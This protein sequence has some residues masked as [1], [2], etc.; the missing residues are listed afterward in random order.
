MFSWHIPRRIYANYG[1]SV[2][3]NKLCL[4]CSYSYTLL[5]DIF[6]QDHSSKLLLI[7]S[8]HVAGNWQSFY[9]DFNLRQVL[10]VNWFCT[11]CISWKKKKQRNF[12][13]CRN[14]KIAARIKCNATRI[15]GNFFTSV[16]NSK[17]ERIS[18]TCHCKSASSWLCKLWKLLFLLFHIAYRAH[19]MWYDSKCIW[20]SWA[21]Q[22]HT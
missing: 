5:Q 16:Q 19:N 6:R 18:V 21:R 17:F 2:Y 9:H 4:R 8:M 15:I 13:R 22:N 7:N 14:I 11:F 10:K 20:V 1:L 12:L 3:C